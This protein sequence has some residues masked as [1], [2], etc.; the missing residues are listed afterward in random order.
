MDDLLSYA[1]D[2]S[3]PLLGRAI[4]VHSQ[5]LSIH[6]FLDGNGRTSRAV[7]DGMLSRH[8]DQYLSLMVY[9]LHQDTD[10]ISALRQFGTDGTEG[11]THDYWKSAFE[12]CERIKSIFHMIVSEVEQ[13]FTKAFAGNE[14]SKDCRRM[15]SLLWNQGLIYPEKL[16]HEEEWS[17]KSMELALT[18]LAKAGI[19]TKRILKVPRNEVIYDCPII[20]KPGA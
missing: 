17:E 12:H 5:F 6:P 1:N 7:L 8:S 20:L 2:N 10:Y 4:T 13:H 15:L 3:L 19:V 18:N 16:I 9:R 11:L 14:I